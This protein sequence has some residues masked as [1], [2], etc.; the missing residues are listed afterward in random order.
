MPDTQAMSFLILLIVLIGERFLLRYQGMRSAEWFARWMEFHQSLPV[1]RGLRDGIPGLTLLLL[2]PLLLVLMLQGLLGAMLGE[3]AIYLIAAI[4]LLYSLGP[5]D[6]D[7]QVAELVKAAEQGDRS[8]A[9]AIAAALP[10]ADSGS[11]EITS[12][13]VIAE[14]LL[15]AAHRRIFCV[16]FWFLFL[17]PFGALLYRLARETTQLV[18]SQARPGLESSSRRLLYLLD[19]IPSRMLAGLFALAGNFETSVQA[20]HQ[21]D[22]DD[23]DGLQLTRCTGAGALQ[24]NTTLSRIEAAPVDSGMIQSAMSLVWRALVFVVALLGLATIS[25]FLA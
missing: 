11:T 17:G 20:W 18:I 21:C 2:P 10:D 8:R 7:S 14:N 22:R 6:L 23:A 24:L 9:E 25:A 1:G 13:H 5:D 4:V 16:L 19:W 15:C 3:V 12:D